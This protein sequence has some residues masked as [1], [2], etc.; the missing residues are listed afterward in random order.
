LNLPRLR[1][2]YELSRRG[3]V[4][5]VAEAL[6]ITPSAVSQQ[7]S[8]LEREVGTDLVERVGRAVR[9]T[10][11]GRRLALEAERVLAA[12]DAAQS[13]ADELARADHA[14]L[15]VAAFPSVLLGLLSPALARLRSTHPELTVEV[16]D[17]EGAVGLDLVR[18]GRAD[19]AVIDDWG[20]DLGAEHAGLEVTPLLSDPM[21]AVLPAEHGLTAAD[22]VR[23]SDLARCDWVIEPGE[24]LFTQQ[25]TAHCRRAGFEPRVRARVRDFATQA[26]LVRSLGLVTVLPATA[27]TPTDEVV[28]RSLLPD[29]RRRLMLVSRD[30]GHSSAGHLT[31]ALQQIAGELSRSR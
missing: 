5:A 23:W 3:S 25:I 28:T 8:T 17:V 7:L 21:L 26:A 6:W 14:A 1:I 12:V 22:S 30:A 29:L 2:L 19:L 16:I 18:L 31:T 20:W 11:A 13:T 9:P 10:E 15:R 24:T 4:S 27:A